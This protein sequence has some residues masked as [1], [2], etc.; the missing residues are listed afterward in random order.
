MKT[1]YTNYMQLYN[2]MWLNISSI[3][4]YEIYIIQHIILYIPLGKN[5]KYI[6]VIKDFDVLGIKRLRQ[7]KNQLIM[8]HIVKWYT[9]PPNQYNL[10]IHKMFVKYS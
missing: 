8:I 4:L 5:Q 7:R 9:G 6:Y 3:I 10:A 1:H 2:Q